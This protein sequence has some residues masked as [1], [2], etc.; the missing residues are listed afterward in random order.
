VLIAGH[1]TALAQNYNGPNATD[2]I[3]NYA[4]RIVLSVYGGRSIAFDDAVISLTVINP[5]LV[6][7]E[8]KN[9]RFVTFTGLAQG[10]TIVIVFGTSHRQIFA[11]EVKGPLVPTPEQIAA[12]ALREQRQRNAPSGSYSLSFSPAFAGGPSVLRQS[13]DY[14]RQ[15]S[16]N[17]T[18]RIEGNTFKF[19]GRGERGLTYSTEPGFG[20]DRLSLGVDAPK[21]RLD[22]L[23]SELSVSS[24]SLNALTMR[25]PHLVSLPDSRLRG[26]E[27]FAGLARPSFNFLENTA[28]YLG[29]VVVPIA[30]GNSW[31][32][33]AGVLAI[34]SSHGQKGFVWHTDARYAPSA[35]FA[36]EAELD[37]SA[38][39]LSW[40]ARFDLHRGQFDIYGE[41]LRQ[42]QRSALVSIGAQPGRKMEAVRVGWQ[43]TARLN[44]SISYNHTAATLLRSQGAKLNSSTLYANANFETTRQSR[45]G[46]R[47]IEQQI[48]TAPSDLLPLLKLRTRSVGVTHSVSFARHWANDFEGS[49]TSSQ[50]LKV[51]AGM[52]RG[53]ELR[54]QLRR[55]WEHWSATGYINYARNTPSLASLIVRNPQLLPPALRRAF[56]SDPARFILLNR[57]ALP[58]LLAG[59]ELPS[60][61]SLDVGLRFQGVFSRYNLSGDVRYSSGDILGHSRRDLIASL[62]AGIR[63]DSAN[64]V[65]VSGVRSFAPGAVLS[66]SALTISYTHRFGAGSGDGFKFSR[67]LGLDRG[68]VQGRVFFDLNSNGLDDP[69]EPGIANMKVLLDADH[70]VTTGNDGRF[71]FSAIQPGDHKVVLNSDDLG[72]RVRASTPTEQQMFLSARDTIKVSFGLTNFGYVSGRVFNNLDLTS[73][74]DSGN[75][76]GVAGVKINLCPIGDN[77]GASTTTLTVD[78]S[79][80]YNFR[81]LAP[82]SYRL[83]IDP[84]TI[85]ADFQMP[86]QRSWELNVEPLK[87]SYL[88]IPLS[89]QRAVSGIV[90]RDTDNDGRFDPQKDEVLEGARVIAGRVETLSDRKGSYILRNLPAGRVA[91]RAQIGSG[92]VSSIVMV[93]LAA[94]PSVRRAVNLII[95]GFQ[96]SV[97]GNR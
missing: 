38:G 67:L 9:G 39:A 14:R 68:R 8:L 83:E 7:A 40:R 94:E 10:E 78:A 50:E 72:V 60:T 63:L 91:I 32:L 31:Q 86:A 85:P 82:G 71:E 1:I 95:P 42:D 34:A 88:E 97:S 59:I 13:F 45:L 15:L 54:D 23:D 19:F 73:D 41:S 28:G 11:V 35:N 24:L 4:S 12:M 80:M 51:G 75:E 43:P 62:G 65:Q 37:Y 6:K 74:R 57:D 93:A 79:G 33:R 44:A 29:G 90:F 2:Q 87:G 49:L 66:P 58:L 84:L 16:N 70:R 64:S 96:K 48:E 69:G 36:T 21:G 26:L 5:E 77:P 27:L 56:E 92:E 25:G 47:F 17:R 52:E 81:S 18:L 89:A 3:H 22:L 20:L 76:P 30:R 53:I 61:R 46:F 55:S